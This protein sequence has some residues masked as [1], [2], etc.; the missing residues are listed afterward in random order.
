MQQHLEHPFGDAPVRQL[1][2]GQLATEEF[3]RGA[4]RVQ[5]AVEVTADLGGLLVR[6]GL[7]RHFG[8]FLG[9]GFARAIDQQD[10]GHVHQDDQGEDGEQQLVLQ[11]KPG[12]HRELL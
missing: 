5:G 4:R 12:Q 2:I 8:Q 9:L 7:H 1:A 3:R 10:A 11:G 6:Y